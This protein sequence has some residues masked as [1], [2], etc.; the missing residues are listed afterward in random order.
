MLKFVEAKDVA[1]KAGVDLKQPVDSG[2]S[3]ADLGTLTMLVINRFM[4][5][6][7]WDDIVSVYLTGLCDSDD[8]AIVQRAVRAL[9]ESGV[10]YV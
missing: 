2:L 9:M 1:N 7:A 5:Q 6:V 3:G 4:E 10:E 8:L